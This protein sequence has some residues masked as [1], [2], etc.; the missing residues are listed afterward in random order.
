L[1]PDNRPDNPIADHFVE[2]WLK[3]HPV[4]VKGTMA[5]RIYRLDRVSAVGFAPRH[6]FGR[7]VRPGVGVQVDK[8]VSRRSLP[9]SST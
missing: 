6:T 4:H 7:G 9:Q 5:Q 2:H 1:R 3:L 8:F